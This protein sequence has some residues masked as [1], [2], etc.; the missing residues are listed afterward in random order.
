M[1]RE[2]TPKH[3]FLPPLILVLIAFLVRLIY[4]GFERTVWGDEPFY[5]WLGRN[6]FRGDGYTFAFSGHWDYHHTPGYPF[7]TAVLTFVTGDMRRASEWSYILFGALL[8]LVIYA[9][10]TRIYG[11]RS[12]F[13]A[14][15][16]T[17]LAPATALMPLYWGTMTE[18]PYLALAFTGMLFAHRAYRRFRF[19]DII[20]AAIFLAFAYYVRPESIV[21]LGAMGLVLGLRALATPPRLRNL[22]YPALLGFVFFVLLF[23]YLYE[24]RQATGKW[25]V[26]QKVGAHFATAKG[27]A[28]GRF[29]QFDIETWGL[30]SQGRNVR[31]FSTETADADAASY[32]LADPIGYAKVVYGNALKLLNQITSPRLFPAFGL[33][34]LGLALFTRAWNRRRGWDELFLAATLLTGISFIFFFVQERYLAPL[35]PTLFI[36][37]GH[38]FVLMGLWLGR[39]ARNLIKG[40]DRPIAAQDDAWETRAVWA[41]LILLGAFMLIWTPRQIAGATNPGSTRP[42]HDLA[43][44]ALA[45]YAQPGDIVMARYVS[46]PFEAGTE[47]VPTPAADLEAVLKYARLKNAR[48]WV[49][50]A[51]EA[52]I[53][54]PQFLPLIEDPENPPPGLQYLTQVDDGSG[55]VV[56]YR[57]E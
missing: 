27:L 39:T 2:S 6:W 35:I 16:I 7:I 40:E 23:P 12:G 32:I 53:L 48:Y 37:F 52:R 30:D 51:L 49:V 25:T 14:G 4:S 47:W 43:A 8:V 55:P 21:F 45:Q 29:Q 5:L 56:I 10:A 42:A 44:Q 18:P 31:F 22:A 1:N 26:S 17:A 41:L 54:R 13:A 3:R 15:L 50:D 34:F 19:L 9:L 46:I 20:F 11:W 24:V 33:L 36:W 28:T 38:G 57:L